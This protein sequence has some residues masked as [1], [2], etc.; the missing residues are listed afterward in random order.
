MAGK[1]EIGSFKLSW[2]SAQQ[3]TYGDGIDGLPTI[4]GSL[5]QSILSS[6]D[7]TDEVVTVRKALRIAPV[8]TCVNVI[9]M[10]MGA[11]PLGYFEKIG[12]EKNQLTDDPAYYGLAHE[13]NEYMSSPNFWMTI[14]LHMIG[15]GNGYAKI[16]RD[17]RENPVMYEIWEPWEVTINKDNGRLWYTYKGETI[18]SWDILHYRVQ[19]LDG[20]CGLSAIMEN[21]NTMAMAL[22]LMRY[23]SL[24]TGAQPPGVLSY[25][26]QL[27]PEQKAENKKEWNGGARGSVKV[28]SGKWAYN[29]IMTPGDEVQYN[30][31]KAAN[32]REIYGILKTPPTFAQN[33]ERATYTN[34]EQSDLVYAKHTVTPYCTIIEKENNMKL[35][36][37]K[38][39]GTRYWKFN[40]NGL[41]RGDLAARS[42]FYQ[43]MINTGV[44]TRNE[45]RSLEDMNSYEG[46]DVPMVQGAMIPADQEGVDALRKK[47]ETEVIPSAPVTKNKVNGYSHAN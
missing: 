40:M 34:A 32:D 3:R 16:I 47:M 18:S 27:S 29:P 8:W 26:G 14:I 17:S 7:Y 43:S 25:E 30:A 41:L 5:L 13:P 6:G 31:T 12:G 42:G 39:K 38:K 37:E 44:F 22:K 46:G 15:W 23:M 45:A 2:G 19:S 33:F 1:L 11:L 4:N 21:K 24:I 9:S 28:L 20:I 35:V 36:P 10:T